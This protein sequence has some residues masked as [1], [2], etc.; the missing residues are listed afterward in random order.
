MYSSAIHPGLLEPLE[1]LDFAQKEKLLEDA[2]YAKL[3]AMIAR[4][5]LKP[6]EHVLEIGCGWGTC[7]LRMAQKAGVRVTG[8]T[9]SNEQLLEARAKVAAAGLSD[10]INIVF[11]DYRRVHELPTYPEGGFDKV[12]SIEMLEAVGHEH[13]H[14]YFE[15]VERYLKPGGLAAV[16]VI[17]LPD[18]RYKDYCEQRKPPA[19]LPAALC[20]RANGCNASMAAACRMRTRLSTHTHT[21]QST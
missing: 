21:L 14:S 4:V 20:R 7:A 15:C 19:Q 2:Q 9:V 3:D 8:I 17:T 10:R 13:L 16:Q 12:V 1:G 6:G 5:E 11:C 18:D